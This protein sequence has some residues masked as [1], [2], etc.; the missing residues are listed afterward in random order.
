MSLIIGELWVRLPLVPS[1]VSTGMV[2]LTAGCKPAAINCEAEGE[3][4][5]SFTIHSL[6]RLRR[7]LARTPPSQ[8]GKGGS[9][10]LGATS[11]G[12]RRGRCP[13]GPHKAGPPGSIPGPETLRA[14]RCSAEFHKLGSR[15]STPGP[16]ILTNNE[17][18]SIYQE[19][20]A[21]YANWH[22]GQAESLMSVGSTPTRAIDCDS[23]RCPK[24]IEQTS[25][26]I[27][28]K[29]I[30]PFNPVQHDSSQPVR[31]LFGR[32]DRRTVADPIGN[33]S[34]SVMVCDEALSPDLSVTATPPRVRSIR[35][36]QATSWSSPH[37]TCK[38]TLFSTHPRHRIR[39]V[40]ST[41]A[42]ARHSSPALSGFL[43]RNHLTLLIPR[44]DSKPNSRPC[45][46]SHFH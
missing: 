35:P 25:Q 15:G 28:S 14:G 38:L 23:Q 34:A 10:P 44:R 11:I 9:T 29:G 21:R 43:T 42:S 40:C 17:Q 13:A 33:R 18:L 46:S 3:R 36:V 26:V 8:G 19:A 24:Q 6:K 31:E 32:A 39:N 45:S 1:F 20:T 27:Q 4:F 22:S 2:L 37:C 12:L 41:T 16:A 5:N 7:L 30:Q